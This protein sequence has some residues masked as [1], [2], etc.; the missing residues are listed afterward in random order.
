MPLTIFRNVILLLFSLILVFC[1]QGLN[2]QCT[3][4][5]FDLQV[6][7][8]DCKTSMKIYAPG[9]EI[10]VEFPYTDERFFDS[11]IVLDQSFHSGN[12]RQ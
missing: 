2:A 11:L 12:Y 6:T 7:T 1:F 4:P 9:G 3:I 5:G 10:N 8:V